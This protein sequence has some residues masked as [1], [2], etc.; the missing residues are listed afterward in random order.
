[1]KT[2]TLNALSGTRYNVASSPVICAL[3]DF[4]AQNPGLD[5]ANYGN[6]AVYGSEARSISAD[7]RRVKAAL[8]ECAVEGVT[9]ADVI[10]EAPHAFSGRLTWCAKQHTPA[11][12]GEGYV[13]GWNYCT[14]QY[15]PTEY[16]KAVA[17]VLEYAARKARRNRPAVAQMPTTISELK[18]LNRANGS[19]WFE[20]SAMR[21]FGTR[22]EGGI[23]RGRYFVT[24]EQPPHG[25]RGYT[26]R[27]FDA[28]GDVDTVGEL[29]G[30]GSRSEAIA[31]IP[32]E[33]LATA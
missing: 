6:H 25:P 23:I 3:I 27:S 2:R 12:T 1:M 29:C 14:G 28:Q 22:I 32:E 4:A 10:A 21:F 17:T 16:R 24:S 19:C 11:T 7:W 33:E 18:A 31:A 13:G 30:H 20:P 8:M 15:F 26:L 5:F 9:D